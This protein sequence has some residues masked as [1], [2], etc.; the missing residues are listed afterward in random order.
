MSA[1]FVLTFGQKG[2]TLY[3]SEKKAKRKAFREIEEKRKGV[4][5]RGGETRKFIYQ[6]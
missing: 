4:I 3:F 6:Q 2:I 1:N 5:Y